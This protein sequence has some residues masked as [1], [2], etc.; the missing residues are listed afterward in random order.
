MAPFALSEGRVLRQLYPKPPRPF[1]TYGL[2]VS[3]SDVEVAV[4]DAGVVD[5]DS[6]TNSAE[7]AGLIGAQPLLAVE[8]NGRITIVGDMPGS[9]TFAALVDD[10][11]VT[12]FEPS[13]VVTNHLHA[14]RTGCDTG[15]ERQQ[16]DACC[17]SGKRGMLHVTSRLLVGVRVLNES[18]KLR[19][20]ITPYY[21]YYSIFIAKLQCICQKVTPYEITLITSE[22][23][24]RVKLT[25]RS[26]LADGVDVRNAQGLPGVLSDDAIGATLDLEPGLEVLDAP[27][28]A[29][30][31]L[32]VGVAG[33]DHDL[34]GEEQGLC[35]LDA[36]TGVPVPKGRQ[37]GCRCRRAAAP[38]GCFG[39]VRG[40]A[41]KEQ[42]R[43]QCDQQSEQ[44]SA[45]GDGG[46]QGEVH[47][48]PFG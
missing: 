1:D 18:A 16:C 41:A 47:G 32:P 29:R 33:A 20:S 17:C 25:M 31:E 6:L 35:V 10:H 40:G 48:V 21:L 42:S 3:T 9:S 11:G 5:L 13:D 2:V 28:G 4:H 26:A 45:S 30:S 7:R 36:R 27:E 34:V 8:R 37:A 38:G 12:L 43:N 19:H 46:A 39:A 14:R 23:A 15:G 24:T 22:E 44:S